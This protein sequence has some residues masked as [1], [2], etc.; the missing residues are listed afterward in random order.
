LSHARRLASFVCNRCGA[1]E[2]AEPGSLA[3]GTCGGTLDLPAARLGRPDFDGSGPWRYRAWLPIETTPVTLGEP[4]T[5]LLAFEWNHLAATF[6]FEGSLPS[7][8]FKD[9]GAAVLV[10]WLAGNGVRHVADDSSGNAGA[11]LAAYCARAGITCDIYLPANT[12]PAKVAQIEAYGARL[13][14]VPGS[15]EASAD[16]V[17][18]AAT[19][20]V[21]YASHAWSPLYLAGTATF[22][23]ELWEQLDRRVPDL[24]VFP[25]GGGSL[26]L[27]AYL[28]F[29]ALMD[30]GYTDR[31]PRLIGAQT[32]ACAP[33][34]R[35]HAAGSAEPVA[36]EPGSSAAGGILVAHPVRGRAVLAAVASTSGTIVAIEDAEF[37]AAHRDL[38]RSGIFVEPTSAVAVAALSALVRDHLVKVGETVV[39]ALT[40]HGLKASTAGS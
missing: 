31:V 32:Q 37:L 6:K 28:G 20:E 2:T 21:V 24:C 39:V 22:A 19:E 25:V 12:P 29:R 26:L 15:R 35:A 18:E 11:A 33:L 9:R 30:A 5:P 10:S 38:A 40:G 27:G 16:A 36:V 23:Y 1:E 7:G 14:R 4:T 3:C 13:V 17:K 34:A 8:S